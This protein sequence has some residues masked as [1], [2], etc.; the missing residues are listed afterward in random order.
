M[1]HYV[2]LANYTEDGFE[3]LSEMDSEEFLVQTK[4]TIE[5]HGGELKDYYL[6]MGQYDAVGIAEFPDDES[7]AKAQ[8]TILSTGIAETETL[9]AFTEEQTREFVDY[10]GE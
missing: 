6:T 10:L 7:I 4:E 9:K 2:V 5:A 3:T 8:L 1:P